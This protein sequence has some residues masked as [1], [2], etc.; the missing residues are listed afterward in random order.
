M[1]N[2]ASTPVFS[3]SRV[4]SFVPISAPELHHV[5]FVPWD[6]HWKN[7]KRLIPVS[8]AMQTSSLRAENWF[9]LLPQS[10]LF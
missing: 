5:F 2:G 10:K 8:D 6:S 7:G 9:P 3:H 1:L 4:S